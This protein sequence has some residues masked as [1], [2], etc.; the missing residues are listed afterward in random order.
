MSRRV[1]RLRRR[2]RIRLCHLGLIVVVIITV[3]GASFGVPI[4]VRV[5]PVPSGRSVVVPVRRRVVPRRGIARRRKDCVGRSLPSST[6]DGT[7]DEEPEEVERE[8]TCDGCGKEES[9]VC[10]DNGTT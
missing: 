10:T 8:E 1:I 5:V 6:E 7:E 2:L 4:G 3:R 9:A